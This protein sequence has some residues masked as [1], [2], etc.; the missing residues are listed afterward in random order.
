MI[1]FVEMP[2]YSANWPSLLDGYRIAF[3]AD[4]HMLPHEDLREAI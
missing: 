3:M 4:I 2:F 1:R